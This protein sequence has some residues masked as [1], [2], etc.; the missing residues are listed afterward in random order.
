MD[1][2]NIELML[3]V[4]IPVDDMDRMVSGP[5]EGFAITWVDLSDRSDL[6]HLSDRHTAGAEGELLVTF[7]YSN[8]GKHNMRIGLRIQMIRPT[9]S[10]IILAFEVRKFFDQL[11]LVAT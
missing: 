1:E 2:A 10:V 8:P 6:Q 5:T 4:A 9:Q 3:R 7:F 11:R